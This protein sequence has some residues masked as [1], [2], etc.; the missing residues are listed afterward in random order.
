MR[1]AL[2]NKEALALLRDARALVLFALFTLL[3]AALF[4]Q[5]GAD[6]RDS[7]ARKEQAEAQA[8][9]QWDQQGDRHP[10][11]GAHFG[12]YVFAPA[13]PLASFD[14]GVTR[15]LGEALWLEPHRRN[16]MRFS[17][18]DSDV[19]S[20]RLGELSPA[21][22]VAS[23][24]PLLIFA[25]TFNAV[26]QE[27]ESGTLRMAFG[28]GIRARDVIASKLLVQ[29]GISA[30]VAM[31]AVSL[32]FVLSSLNGPLAGQ[33]GSDV[34]LRCLGLLGAL[35]AYVLVLTAVGLA[36]SA[37]ASSSQQ[38]L[39]VL[40][41]VW[42]V[43]TLVVPRGAAALAKSTVPLPTAG[44]FWGAIKH[45]YE[46]GLPGD[47]TLAER[48]ARYDAQLLRQYGASRLEDVPAGA[49]ALR[50]LQR[51]A[52]ADRVH[53]LHFGRLWAS[54]QAQEDLVR[55]AGMLSPTVA[56]R[57]ASMKF[58]GTDLAHR[59][60]FEEAAEAYRQYVNTA[61][62]RWDAANSQGL[63]SFEDKYAGNPLWQ[64][65]QRFAYRPPAAAFAFH[66]AAG[67]LML[68]GLW[69]LASLLILSFCAR[70]LRP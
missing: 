70:R 10:H 63:R 19:T 61:I 35:L 36:V 16:T 34:T 45:D 28:A 24:L 7:A 50:R 22:L 43:F 66:S 6:L 13:S 11:R 26:S 51:D 52:Y 20:M 47:G 39:A 58:A 18:A 40:V 41:M 37:A 14:P 59:R 1:R 30:L 67:A 25:L 38:A 46:M 54:Y 68:L 42:I 5:G 15:Y 69:A 27:R 56:M 32:V 48:G 49:Y 12:L 3:F 53:A 23:A 8:R 64:S 2:I 17:D 57:L 29:C 55:A 21:F 4:V 62:D 31:L 44:Q 65:V 60:H 33:P 9:Q